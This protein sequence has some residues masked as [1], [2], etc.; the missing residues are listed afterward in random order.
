MQLHLFYFLHFGCKILLRDLMYS[1]PSMQS[2]TAICTFI[3]TKDSSVG[4][5]LCAS[6][7]AAIDKSQLSSLKTRFVTCQR[8]QKGDLFKF[9]RYF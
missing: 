2:L 5:T 4:A 1:F 7:A 3:K 6:S 9:N 8:H